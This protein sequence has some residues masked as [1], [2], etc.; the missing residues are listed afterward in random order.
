[1]HSY[2][3]SIA[4][5]VWVAGSI[6]CTGSL[7]D[8]GFGG[9]GQGGAA[10]QG[11]A[12]NGPSAANGSN[13]TGGTTHAATGNG[14]TNGA[15]GTAA[16]GNTAAA[17]GATTDATSANAT[18]G[19]TSTA[20]TGG[21]TDYAQHCVDTINGYRAT[22]GLAPYARWQSNES[23]VDGQA[24]ADGTANSPHSAFGD[25]GEWAQNECPGWS[26]TPLDIID[27]C[28]AQ[29]WAEGPGADFNTHGHY[30]N[31]TSTSYTK[32]ACGAHMFGG[33]DTWA[34][35]DFQ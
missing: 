3:R 21:G 32:A 20:S 9:S 7:S 4:L 28:L 23:C 34:T 17:N 22:L 16:N 35:Q 18:V 12:G 15:S 2:L 27:G 8:D 13:A 14:A 6:G 26:G 33:G 1:M 30:I 31:M 25:C 11:P 24:L 19:A 10:A 5:G 29:M